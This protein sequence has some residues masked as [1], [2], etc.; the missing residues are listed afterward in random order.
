MDGRKGFIAVMATS[1]A[2]LATF[3]KLEVTTT[4]APMGTEN[5][6]SSATPLSVLRC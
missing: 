4:S 5:P 2:K 6:A 3:T 1:A